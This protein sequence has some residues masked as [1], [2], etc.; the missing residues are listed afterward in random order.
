MPLEGPRNGPISKVPAGQWPPGHEWP[1]GPRVAMA[2]HP[3]DTIFGDAPAIAELREQIRHLASFDTP[4]NPHVPTVLMQGE[5]G[6]G[7]GLVARRDPRQRRP[8]SGP[9]VDVNCAAIPGDHARGGA[10]RLR[11]RRLH[12]CAARQAGALRGG[13]RAAASS[14]TR[15]TRCRSTLQG[16]LLKAIEEKRVR[17]LGAVAAPQST[18]KLIAATQKRPARAG[19]RAGASAPTCT[20]GWRSSFSSC[21]RCAR[22]GADV[23]ALAEHFLARHTR[24]RTAWR[25]GGSTTARARGSAAYDWPGNV[26]ELSHLMERVTLLLHDEESAATRWS[27]CACRSRPRGAASRP[28]PARRRRRRGGRASATR[29]RAPAATSCA[30]RSCSVSAATRSAIACSRHGIE[31]PTLDEPARAPARAATRAGRRPPPAAPRRAALGAEAGRRAGDRPRRCPRRDRAVDRGAALGAMI[32]ERVAGFGGVCRHA[33]ARAP[34]RGVR[35]PARAR[36]AP[37]ARGA[38]GARDPAARLARRPHA[39]APQPELRMAIHAGTVRV[40]TAARDPAASLLPVGDTL[41]LPERLLGHAG[42]AS[43]SCRAAVARASRRRASSAPRDAPRRRVGD[44]RRA[45]RGRAA[46]ARGAVDRPAAGDD[47]RRPRSASWSCCARLRRRGRRPRPGRVR[48]RRGGHRQ[49]APPGGVPRRARGRA[50]PSGSRAAA[51]PTAT[52]TAF[53]PVV[54]GAPPRLGHRRPRR[55]G[56]RA[57]E[58]RPRRRALGDDLA[59]TLP[60]VRH[61]ARRSRRTIASPRSTPR[62]G[63]ARP[64]GR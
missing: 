28:A 46:A 42:R 40:D 61:V 30:R 48:R 11:G 25:R 3:T 35:R 27:A 5:T 59:W 60:F 10:V 45:C 37:A 33:L 6:T 21:R 29:S 23:L 19:R 20:T 2:G 50:A 12:G 31:R 24:R 38:G 39:R 47:V 56:R 8:G 41:A 51:P 1:R 63:A 49:V 43:S 44:A 62:A 17:R 55:R 26:R 13:R 15:S 9:F 22:R 7:K 36:A 14:S 32:E 18:S 34:D 4:G 64:S 53:L 58:G 54:D 57:R 52:T 16:K